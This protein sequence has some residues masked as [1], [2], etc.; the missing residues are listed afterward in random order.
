MLAQL[1]FWNEACPECTQ[2]IPFVQAPYSIGLQSHWMN[3][4]DEDTG[5]YSLR[6]CIRGVPK[7]DAGQV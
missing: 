1:D 6:I 5:R 3:W 7:A 2:G 4:R